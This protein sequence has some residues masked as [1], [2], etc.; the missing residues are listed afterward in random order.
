MNI[1]DNQFKRI[2]NQFDSQN[3][4]I[5]LF[6]KYHNLIGRGSLIDSLDS[7]AYHFGIGFGVDS[8][9]K[10]HPTPYFMFQEGN[11]LSKPTGSSRWEDLKLK[12]H[13]DAQKFIVKELFKTMSFLDIKK[14]ITTN[15]ILILQE[16]I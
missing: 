13:G 6:A 5:R 1:T 16:L 15:E 14:H 4:V 2:T 8:I 10:K 3:P 7:F 9:T 12:S 11:I